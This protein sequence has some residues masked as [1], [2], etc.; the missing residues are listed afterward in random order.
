MT[1]D[2]HKNKSFQNN[3][4]MHQSRCLESCHQELAYASSRL[5][6]ELSIAKSLSAHN[7]M[8]MGGRANG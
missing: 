3:G 2:K 6:A 8:E 7:K 5:V 4:D 1:N